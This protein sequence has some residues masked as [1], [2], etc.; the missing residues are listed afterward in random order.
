LKKTPHPQHLTKRQIKS[1][2][3]AKKEGLSFFY[4]IY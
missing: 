4:I 2:K 1:K 3:N